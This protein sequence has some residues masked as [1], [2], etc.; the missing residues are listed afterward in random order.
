MA[1]GSNHHHRQLPPV[2]DI[3]R[4]LFEEYPRGMAIAVAIVVAI[5]LGIVVTFWQLYAPGPRRRRGLKRARH[6]LQQGFWQE[7]LDHVRRLRQIGL[8]SQSWHKRFDQA[9]GACLLA[10]SAAS[11][12]DK[13]FEEA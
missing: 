2:P 6:K 1:N 13:E 7:A 9:E 10:A 11:L 4:E 8:P 5:L 12:N 3:L